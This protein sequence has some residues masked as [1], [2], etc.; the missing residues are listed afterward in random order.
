MMMMPDALC[1]YS[2]R[3]S[4]TFHDFQLSNQPVCEGDDEIEIADGTKYTATATSEWSKVNMHK[5]GRRS[6]DPVEWTGGT[7]EFTVRDPI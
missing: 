1:E 7:E 3:E 2:K 4:S 6:I 5:D